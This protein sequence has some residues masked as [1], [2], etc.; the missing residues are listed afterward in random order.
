[1]NKIYDL[2][3]R[4]GATHLVDES[5]KPGRFSSFF[6]FSDAS[7]HGW[8]IIWQLHVF[9]FILRFSLPCSACGMALTLDAAGLIC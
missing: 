3:L 4:F 5:H 9:G 6:G 2:I 7:R 8:T 1:M